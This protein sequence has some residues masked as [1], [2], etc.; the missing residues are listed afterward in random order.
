MKRFTINLL[1]YCC[2]IFAVFSL[3]GCDDDYFEDLDEYYPP[4]F[5]NAPVEGLWVITDIRGKYS[6]YHIDEEWRFY[7][8]GD[9]ETRGFENL[10]E[11]GRWRQAYDEVQ[12]RFDNQDRELFIRIE[13]IDRYRMIMNVT[14]KAYDVGY[15]N[16]LKYKLYL[17]KISDGRPWSSLTTLPQTED[18]TKYSK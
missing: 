5:S 1:T 10:H 17:E 15:E 9:F 6:S 18:S 8:N 2:L 4:H 12:V 13:G 14:D 3:I 7:H 16:K 11:F